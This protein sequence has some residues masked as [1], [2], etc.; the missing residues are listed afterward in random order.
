MLKNTSFKI[1]ASFVIKLDLLVNSGAFNSR[2]EAIRIAIDD[3]I[4][5]NYPFLLEKDKE[6]KNSLE[7]S[8][9]SIFDC[10]FT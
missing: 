7:K 1:P 5:E 9:K 2:G 8:K 6:E 4:N 3:Y 10:Y